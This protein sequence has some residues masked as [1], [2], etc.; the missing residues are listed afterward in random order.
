MNAFLNQSWFVRAWTLQ[1]VV[2]ARDLKLICGDWSMGWRSLFMAGCCIKD[3]RL[4]LTNIDSIHRILLMN[5]LASG[6][7][8]FHNAPLIDILPQARRAL[9]TDPRDSMFAYLG[10][11]IESDATALK[12]DYGE[13]LD[14]VYMRYAMYFVAED[15]GV[16]ML[17]ECFMASTSQSFFPSWVPQWG[18]FQVLANND[19]GNA[20]TAKGSLPTVSITNAM[21]ELNVKSAVVDK[22]AAVGISGGHP[23]WIALQVWDHWQQLR[24]TIEEMKN[25]TH[26]HSVTYPTGETFRTAI[27]LTLSP[28]FVAAHYDKLFDFLTTWFGA[29]LLLEVMLETKTPIPF[30]LGSSSQ[31]DF[32][33]HVSILKLLKHEITFDILPNESGPRSEELLSLLKHAPLIEEEN[34]KLLCR[35]SYYFISTTTDRATILRPALTNRGYL[36]QVSPLCQA[37][38]CVAFFA[39][40]IQ[41]FVLRPK[42]QGDHAPIK[43]Q[44]VGQ[45]CVHGLNY[46]AAW[47]LSGTNDGTIIII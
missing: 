10:L 31:P 20:L 35:E 29:L 6:E 15:C 11:S 41:P 19:T 18:R 3:A 26:N 36:S 14:E 24:E 8:D 27:L 9:S 17:C 43:Y 13:S 21:K 40:A 45:A 4:P 37:G 30:H 16:L 2:V 34:I 5:E 42:A 47:E 12:P 44:I 33:E 22:L 38:D 25:M 1:E 32:S 23:K 28:E 7:T 39:G 46:D